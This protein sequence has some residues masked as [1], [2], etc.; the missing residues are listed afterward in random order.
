[1]GWRKEDS[2]ALAGLALTMLF[3]SSAIATTTDV[4]LDLDGNPGC[5]QLVDNQLINETRDSDPPLYPIEDLDGNQ[6]LKKL[7]LTSN[8]DQCIWYKMSNG[9]TIDIFRTDWCSG[10]APYLG[11]TLEAVNM[12]VTK[13]GGNAGSR[14]HHYGTSGVDDD[15]D[16]VGPGTLKSVAFC[17]GL[18]GAVLPD[19]TVTAK[20][21][22]EVTG[23]VDVNAL[24]DV[25][26]VAAICTALGDDRAVVHVVRTDDVG[27]QT[28]ESCTC[29]APAFECDPDP[30]LAG[31]TGSCISPVGPGTPVTAEDK[32]LRQVPGVIK[33][34]NDGTFWCDDFDGTVECYSFDAWGF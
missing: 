8:P 16:V 19:D 13:G 7:I 21:C 11:A 29:N 31:T 5:S 15:T 3:T 17:T 27:V 28:V 33:H 1:M 22:S 9:D 20:S 30:A 23:T 32:L 34:T 10:E 18:E 6:I 26:G 12:V 24:D 4:V 25:N 2:K 14:V